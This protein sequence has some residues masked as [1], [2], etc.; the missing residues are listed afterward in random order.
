MTELSITKPPGEVLELIMWTLA[1]SLLSWAECSFKKKHRC[2]FVPSP[3]LH[4]VPNIY[5]I[6][7]KAFV[8]QVWLPPFLFC[9]KVQWFGTFKHRFLF[10]FRLLLCALLAKTILIYWFLFLADTCGTEK[11]CLSKQCLEAGSLN[12]LVQQGTIISL[13]FIFKQGQMTLR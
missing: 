13:N 4:R 5:K 3:C 1:W 7:N 2:L 10:V 9:L 8:V 11:Q 6:G 12:C